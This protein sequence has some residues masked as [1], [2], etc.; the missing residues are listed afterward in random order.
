MSLGLTSVGDAVEA[1]TV[2]VTGS[3]FDTYPVPYPAAGGGNANQCR[4]ENLVRK[5]SRV[6]AFAGNDYREVIAT[7][8]GILVSEE[9]QS[10]IIN[11][12]IAG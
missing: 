2:V 8:P 11:S 3:W 9:P 10:P 6:P 12:V 4:Q 5:T 7:T 1:D